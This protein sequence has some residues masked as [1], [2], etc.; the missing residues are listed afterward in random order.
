[1]RWT[2]ERSTKPGFYFV[3]VRG[4]TATGFDSS[5]GV[6]YILAQPHEP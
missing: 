5:A 4:F 3:D 2:K 6:A 1:M